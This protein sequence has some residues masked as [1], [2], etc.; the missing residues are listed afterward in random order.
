MDGIPIEYDASADQY[1]VDMPLDGSS[2]V[3]RAVVVG[4]GEILDQ[5]PVSLPPLGKVIDTESLTAVFEGRT[6]ESESDASVSFDYSGFA[7]TVHNSGRIIFDER[8]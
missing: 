2:D 6:A 8:H 4:I 7:V 3:G 5:D 1:Y